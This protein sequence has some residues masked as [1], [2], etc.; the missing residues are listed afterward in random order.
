MECCLDFGLY[1]EAREP[2]WYSENSS[3]QETPDSQIRGCAFEF[4]LCLLKPID[5]EQLENLLCFSFII[6]KTGIW[7]MPCKTVVRIKRKD[8]SKPRK[9][10]PFNRWQPFSL[11]L[12]ALLALSSLQR[13]Y[14]SPLIPLVSSS[15]SYTISDWVR[16]IPNRSATLKT[17]YTSF[18]FPKYV[19]MG[20]GEIDLLEII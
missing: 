19:I 9:L 14:S 17:R 8:G 15:L 2:P 4:L 5:F 20:L 12:M 7:S 18:Y 1:T 6:L 11:L 13:P 16:R 3:R 10:K